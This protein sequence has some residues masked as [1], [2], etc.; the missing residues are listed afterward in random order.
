MLSMKMSVDEL[1]TY[2]TIYSCRS[3]WS[4]D[5]FGIDQM[6]HYSTVDQLTQSISLAVDE[7]AIDE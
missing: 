6:G 1:A 2:A 7:I 4:V 5:E 3:V